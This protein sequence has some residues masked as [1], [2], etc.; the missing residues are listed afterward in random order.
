MFKFLKILFNK[1]KK[2]KDFFDERYGF[3]LKYG[4]TSKESYEEAKAH[5]YKYHHQYQQASE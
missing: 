5:Y 4:M 1:K 2:E 3:M